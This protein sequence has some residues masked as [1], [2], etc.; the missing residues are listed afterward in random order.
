MVDLVLAKQHLEY[1]DDDRDELIEQFI[2]AAAGWVEGYT[3]LLLA[4]RSV[5]RRFDSGGPY[6]IFAGPE[7]VVDSV[8]YLDGDLVEQTIDPATYTLVDN[9]LYPATAWPNARYGL[10]AT[11]TAG[12][13]DDVPADL[14]SAQLLYIGH[15]FSNRGDD[16]QPEPPA[17][18]K[19]LANPYCLMFV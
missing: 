3:G 9:I 15:L 5:T 6:R 4:R 11:V 1:E 2:A 16:K 7:L 10:V 19:A 12:F 8:K 14:I 17:S 18:A 13:D